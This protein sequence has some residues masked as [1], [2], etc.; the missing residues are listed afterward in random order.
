MQE[1]EMKRF[2][3]TN[4]WADIWFHD[5]PTEYKL[6][7]MYIT[8]HCDGAGVWKVNIPLARFQTG[9][10]LDEKIALQAFDGRIED[11][12]NGKWWIRKFIEFQYGKLSKDCR[13]HN[14]VFQLIESHGL[15]HRVLIDYQKGINT[16]EEEEE[17]KEEGSVRGDVVKIWNEQPRLLPKVT[18]PLSTSRTDQA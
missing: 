6:F 5:L 11:L 15:S 1:E 14:R 18:T 9:V 8:D 12:G 16:L 3:D 17:D 2:T 7:W 13:P 10:V 4:K